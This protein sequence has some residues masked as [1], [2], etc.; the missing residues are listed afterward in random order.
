M[1]LITPIEVNQCGNSLLV[2]ASIPVE[3][4]IT[5]PRPAL[6]IKAVH[7]QLFITQ[8]RLLNAPVAIRHA[9]PKDNH[10]LFLGGF[11]RKDIQYVEALGHTSKCVDGIIRDYV[12]NIPVSGVVDLGCGID[13]PNLEFDENQVYQYARKGRFDKPG[14]PDKERLLSSDYTEYNSVSNILLNQLPEAELVYSQITE[15]NEQLDRQS[16]CG[17]P[18]TEATFK[19]IQD[20]MVIIVQICLTFPKFCS[21]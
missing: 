2:T 16:L 21:L 14:F 18:L 8:C 13:A 10:K 17:A 20:K 19:T 9:F 6:E 11:V 15:M 5:L 4:I 7:Q 1:P 12:V 3:A